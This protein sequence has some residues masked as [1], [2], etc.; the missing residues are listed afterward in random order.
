MTEDK[1]KDK[2]LQPFQLLESGLLNLPPRREKGAAD[3]L[4]AI[5]REKLDKPPALTYEA[6]DSVQ[7]YELGAKSLSFLVVDDPKRSRSV[8]VRLKLDPNDEESGFS[9]AKGDLDLFLLD[10]GERY[11]IR[12][13]QS[14]KGKKSQCRVYE[15]R[16]CNPENERHVWRSSPFRSLHF[17]LLDPD[18]QPEALKSI[19]EIDPKLLTPF[20][21]ILSSG[22][23][24]VRS[25]EMWHDSQT[26]DRFLSIDERFRKYTAIEESGEEE[27]VNM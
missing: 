12:I 22:T 1:G 17:S 24:N 2:S 8:T 14:T 9:D 7:R 21:E 20:I 18:L 25:T 16:E 26:V 13:E 15:R 3:Q 10:R 5:I 23:S 11:A 4:L 19:T 6:K 27:K